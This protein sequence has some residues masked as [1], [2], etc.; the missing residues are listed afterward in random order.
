[1][2][3]EERHHAADHILCVISAEYLSKPYYELGTPR[4]TMGGRYRPAE[5]RTSRLHRAL[6]GQDAVCRSE[7]LRTL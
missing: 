5:L 4:R 1:M 6:R 3:R 7:T 2:D